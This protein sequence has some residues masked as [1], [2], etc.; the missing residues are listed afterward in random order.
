[1]TQS[2][3]SRLFYIPTNRGCSESIKAYIGEAEFLQQ[4]F[5]GPVV[6]AVIESNDAAHVNENRNAIESLRADTNVQ[7][8]HFTV[9]D[10]IEFVD[11]LLGST[12]LANSEKS[13]VRDLL[14]PDGIAYSA[15]PNKA[16]LLA[17]ALGAT[18][19]HRRDS[20][21]VPMEHDRKKQYASEPEAEFIGRRIGEVAGL[22]RHADTMPGDA[23]IHF[24]GSDY[25]GDLPVDRMELIEMSPE[26]LIDL[27][28]L[29]SPGAPR[30][31]V[32]EYV[33]NYYLERNQFAYEGDNVEVDQTG[34]TELGVCCIHAVFRELPEMPIKGTL[35]CDY[36]QKNLLYRLDW[37]VLY[38][39]RRADHH[40]TPDRDTRSDTEAFI[41]Y[42]YRD[43]RY[44]ILWRIWSKHNRTLEARR[45][46]LVAARDRL[47][48]TDVYVAS[49]MNALAS[50][51]RDELI[52]IPIE[53]AKI[54]ERAATLSGADSQEKYDLLARGLEENASKLTDEV[55]TGVRDYCF[56]IERWSLL[57]AAA[58]EIGF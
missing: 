13:R 14:L 28:A 32:E 50:T 19:I 22:V 5:S 47:I 24:V 57:I 10:Q 35:G 46:E 16:S 7:L 21:T 26:L 17:A 37:P 27:E 39:T 11:R 4:T 58:R 31:E 56:L 1:M 42:N 53:M 55:I 8:V 41:N 15:G 43:A 40:Y 23:L 12:A 6:F 18:V 30:E 29:E 2:T 49:F 20:D 51:P 44:K 52:G 9:A 34:K 54:F 3:V 36:F 33:T 38:H 25:Q 48:N 45:S